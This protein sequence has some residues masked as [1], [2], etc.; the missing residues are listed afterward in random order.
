L[1]L[2][3]PIRTSRASNT[4]KKSKVTKVTKLKTIEDI[5]KWCSNPETHPFNGTPM[6]P[7]SVEYQKIYDQAYSILKKWSRDDK[8]RLYQYVQTLRSRSQ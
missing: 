3:K 7:N 1:F 6:F 4:S 8:N 5:E 2:D